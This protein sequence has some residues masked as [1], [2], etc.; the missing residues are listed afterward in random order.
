MNDATQMQT[1]Y[2]RLGGEVG[3]QALARRFYDIMDSTPAYLELREMHAPDLEQVRVD[4]MGFL[5]VWLGGPRDWIERRGTFCLMSRHAGMGITK[6]TADLWLA[7]MR[8]AMDGL[9]ADEVLKEQMNN[10]FVRLAKAMAWRGD[11]L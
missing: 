4:F 3:V 8:Q 6:E 5:S 1:A 7:A 2:E 11:A 9:V 10:A